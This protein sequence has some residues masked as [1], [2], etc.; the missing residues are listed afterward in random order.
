MADRWREV[1][2]C[3]E[4]EDGDT[5]VTCQQVKLDAQC[6]TPYMHTTAYLLLSNFNSD[7]RK[8]SLER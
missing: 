5:L 6:H 4:K 7:D 8:V 1:A 3:A 2:Q